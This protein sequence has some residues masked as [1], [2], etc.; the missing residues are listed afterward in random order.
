MWIQDSF[1]YVKIAGP[2]WTIWDIEKRYSRGT[3]HQLLKIPR[4]ISKYFRQKEVVFLSIS[5]LIKTNL[6]EVRL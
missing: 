6:A 5:M 2:I 1:T 3:K 4:N